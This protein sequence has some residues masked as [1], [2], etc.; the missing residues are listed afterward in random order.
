M[1]VATNN[2]GPSTLHCGDGERLR[3]RK[4]GL[5]FLLG[6]AKIRINNYVI[7]LGFE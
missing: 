1:Q 7:N 3:G 4:N 6:R 5:L 2:K